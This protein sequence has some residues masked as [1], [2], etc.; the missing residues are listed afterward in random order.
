MGVEGVEEVEVAGAEA[1]P[2]RV[3]GSGGVEAGADAGDCGDVRRVELGED[4]FEDQPLQPL[5]LRRHG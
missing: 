2:Q 1:A 4:G 5:E 3:V